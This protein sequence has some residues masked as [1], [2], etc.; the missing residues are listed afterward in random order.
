MPAKS[1]AQLRLMRAAAHGAKLRQDGPSP[2]QARK[3]LRHNPHQ[4]EAGLP[5]HKGSRNALRHRN[6][7]RPLNAFAHRGRR[8]RG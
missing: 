7:L 5:E 4:R 8:A 2:A 1:K 3:F 6:A